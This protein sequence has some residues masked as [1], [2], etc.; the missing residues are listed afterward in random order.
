MRKFLKSAMA[1]LLAAALLTGN[2]GYAQAAKE[3]PAD[4]ITE[5]VVSENAFA[6]QAAGKQQSKAVVQVKS[7]KSTNAAYNKK[8]KKAYKKFLKGYFEK[9]KS[10]SYGRSGYKWNYKFSEHEGGYYLIY[11]INNDGK[12]ELI[13]DTSDTYVTINSALFLYYKGKVKCIGLSEGSHLGGPWP[14]GGMGKFILHSEDDCIAKIK[15]EECTEK[16][17]II[18]NGKLKT[19]AKEF[20]S[21]IFAGD[22]SLPVKRYWIGKKIVSKKKFDNFI[23]KNAGTKNPKRIYWS[24]KYVQYK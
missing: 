6:S 1:I 13:L 9:G 23:K 17:S 15:K 12:L 8:A 4:T 16:Y 2:T 20:E 22:D 3:R 14:F 11:D 21:I 5:S 18:K 7:K 19:V 24:D 10:F